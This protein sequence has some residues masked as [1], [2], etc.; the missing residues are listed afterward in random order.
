MIVVQDVCRRDKWLKIKEKKS[1]EKIS[2]NVSYIHIIHFFL[3]STQK[4][5]NKNYSNSFLYL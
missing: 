2:A 3:N 1:K 5:K 4:F